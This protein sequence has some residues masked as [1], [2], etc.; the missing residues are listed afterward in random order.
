MQAAVFY[1]SLTEQQ[2]KDLTE[3]IAEDIFFLD[4]DLQSEILKLLGNVDFQLSEKVKIR[5][6]F[7]T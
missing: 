3:A 7:T 6:N 4:D 2:K 5:N 1:N